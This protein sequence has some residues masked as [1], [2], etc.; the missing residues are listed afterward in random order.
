MSDREASAVPASLVPVRMLAPI[1]T[2]ITLGLML[3]EWAVVAR[4]AAPAVL[5][6]FAVP[7][8]ALTIV[9]HGLA[10]GNRRRAWKAAGYGVALQS[11]LM[12]PASYALMN[13]G[14]FPEAAFLGLLG[15]LATCMIGGVVSF[16]LLVAISHYSERRDLAS[17]DE[18]LGATAAWF[19]AMHLVQGGLFFT[20]ALVP[21]VVA[22]VATAVAIGTTVVRCAKRRAWC[23]RV[24][25][26]EV[27]G[28]RVRACS[29]SDVDPEIPAIDD[30]P[31]GDFAIVE[32]TDSGG[33]PYRNGVVAVT[34]ITLESRLGV[35]T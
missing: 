35:G 12:V 1:A 14:S 20:S 2:G 25:R 31:R 9:A 19:F 24:E 34:F 23:R 4:H 28:L 33:S 5:V 29:E 10:T 7:A 22:M 21:F 16:P 15:A 13:G 30:L 26:G 18:L 8:V 3:A 6:A 17:G 11:L 32:R 27:A